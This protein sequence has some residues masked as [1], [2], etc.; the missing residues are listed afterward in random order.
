L[1]RDEEVYPTG[2]RDFAWGVY[3][4]WCQLPLS[5][6]G[7]ERAT[8]QGHADWVT[9]VAFSPDGRTLASAGGDP[10]RA[11]RPGEIKLGDAASGRERATLKGHT[12]FVRSVAFSPDGTTLASGSWDQTIKLWDAHSGQERATL[13]GH[14]HWVHCVVFSP[15]GT[16]LA[17]GSRDRTIR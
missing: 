14:T 5:E 1:L 4:R 6:K 2:E 8:L 11:N 7:L 9:S 3:N 17:S 15:D 16:T 10:A 13:R 12:G